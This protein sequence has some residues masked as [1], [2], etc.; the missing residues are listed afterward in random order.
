MALPDIYTDL[1]SFGQSSKCFFFKFFYLKKIT[2]TLFEQWS[3]KKF[4]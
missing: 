2:T 1:R 3:Y 4:R